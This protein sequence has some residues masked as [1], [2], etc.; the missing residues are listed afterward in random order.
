MGRLTVGTA[1]KTIKMLETKEIATTALSVFAE[2]NTAI[3]G[4]EHLLKAKFEEVR[5]LYYR[6]YR[7][8]LLIL[9]IIPTT[10]SI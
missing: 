4:N 7:I 9:S 6:S 2:L 8:S 10:I 5:L 3:K 1:D